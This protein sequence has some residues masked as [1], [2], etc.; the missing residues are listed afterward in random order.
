MVTPGPTVARRPFWLRLGIARTFI[1]YDVAIGCVR[2]LCDMSAPLGTVRGLARPNIFIEFVRNYSLCDIFQ[3][4]K[5]GRDFRGLVV[6][7][8][9]VLILFLPLPLLR[10]YL[11]P[12]PR[13][14]PLP[15]TSAVCRRR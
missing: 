9:L 5:R 4:R 10:P 11:Y 3:D 8:A 15:R 13:T 14:P 7:L 12:K 2:M 6:L 1:S